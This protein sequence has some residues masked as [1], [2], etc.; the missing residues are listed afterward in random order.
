M[1]GAMMLPEFDQEMASTRKMLEALP[2]DR[3]DFRPHEKSWTLGELASHVS[4]L[5]SWTA[6]TLTTTE[7]DLDQDWSREAPTSREGIL[8]EFDASVAGARPVLEGAAAEDLQVP[9]TLRTG[10]QV[11]FTLPRAAIFRSFVMSHLIH[12]RAQVGV[13]LRML[14]VAVPGMYGPSADESM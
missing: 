7:L 9:W 8:A 1:N 14:D 6:M 3:L 12:H 10:D 13:Y 4:N 11:H 5:P 2:D